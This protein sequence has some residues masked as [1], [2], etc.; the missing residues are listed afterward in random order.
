MDEGLEQ[1]LANWIRS[2]RK[3]G[4]PILRENVRTKA[5]ELAEERGHDQKKFQAS[6]GWIT[7]FARRHRFSLRAGTKHGRKLVFTEEDGVG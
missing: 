4:T 7:K 2:A 1:E 6:D 3:K 5:L